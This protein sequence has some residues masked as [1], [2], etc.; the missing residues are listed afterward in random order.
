MAAGNRGLPSL[1]RIL[2]AAPSA[3]KPA[4]PASREL[5]PFM[6]LLGLYR[7]SAVI[8]TLTNVGAVLNG[9]MVGPQGK[10]IGRA[11]GAAYLS[12]ESIAGF[13]KKLPTNRSNAYPK[14]DALDDIKRGGFLKRYDCRHTGNRALVPPIGSGV[15]PCVVQGPWEFNGV[16]AYYP[17]LQLA[18]P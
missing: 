4:Y 14:A 1:S 9:K 8:G 13:V 11:G 7:S 18:P 16:T 12:N 6:Q 3:L 2:R 10:I 5:I 17:R 15:P